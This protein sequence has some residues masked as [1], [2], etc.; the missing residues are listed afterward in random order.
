MNALLTALITLGSL[1]CQAATVAQDAPEPVSVTSNRHD[2]S[3]SQISVVRGDNALVLVV[4]EGEASAILNGKP[5]PE[6]RLVRDDDRLS[7]LDEEGE[8]VFDV[9]V[10]DGFG[11]AYPYD[12]SGSVIYADQ[13]RFFRNDNDLFTV[14]QGA[15]A[16]AAGRR[17]LIGVTT[18]SVDGVLASQLGLES[19]AAFLINSVSDDMPADVAGMQVNDIVV[20]I[21]GE[22]P[23]NTQLL[24]KHIA[25][26]EAGDELRLS[27]LRGG[28]PHDLS[29]TL[30]EADDSR[31]SVIGDV[32][33]TFWNTGVGDAPFPDVGYV[34]TAVNNAVQR[35]QAELA[36]AEAE[37]ADVRAQLEVRMTDLRDARAAGEDEPGLQARV[38]AV[39]S[40]KAAMDQ[41][42]DVSAVLHA[43]SL[44]SA[45]EV[46]IASTGDSGSRAMWLPGATS[47]SG[48]GRADTLPAPTPPPVT[49]GVADRLERMEERMARLEEML[50]RLIE[51]GN[52]R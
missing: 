5:V 15:Y 40:L 4:G 38:M 24:R 3:H 12:G 32:P 44:R 41:L 10:V 47:R 2:A 42:Q 45:R 30:Q 8:V 18:T 14:A 23:A 17:K 37:L 26:R 46:G 20:S 16:S 6:E 7:V 43:E 1:A 19:D 22:T 11:L 21:E 39:Q 13:D 50:Q 29:L 51:S 27:V 52:G 48:F 35:Q 9:R 36:A 31:Y 25:E 49:P 33:T 28:Q 34:T